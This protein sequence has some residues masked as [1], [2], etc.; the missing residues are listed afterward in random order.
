ML[1]NRLIDRTKVAKLLAAFRGKPPADRD[2]VIAVLI[3]VSEMV[4][5]LPEI[6]EID[7]NPLL[8][9]PDG[10]ICMDARIRASRPPPGKGRHEHLAIR[11]YPRHLVTRDTLDDGTRLIIRPIRPE[12]AESERQFV[13]D[14]SIQAKQFRFMHVMRELTPT[15]LA[16]FTQI[17]YDQEMA[18]V[19]FTEEDGHPVQQGVARYT[20]N[21]DETS[22]E[23][24]VVVSD[25]RQNQGIGTRLM[26]ALMDAARAHGLSMMEGTVLADNG[27]NAAADQGPWLHAPTGA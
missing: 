4:A 11:P 6:E 25:R 23:F 17:D 9:G 24:A 27:A 19:A 2:A 10:V 21:Q 13:K 12:D 7:L 3:R 20:I 15:L 1:A 8:A 16:R 5:E 18:L 22:C 14:L 26:N